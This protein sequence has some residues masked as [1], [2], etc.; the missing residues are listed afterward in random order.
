M[1][2]Q[3]NVLSLSRSYSLI[4][5][6]SLCVSNISCYTGYDNRWRQPQ[7]PPG[8]LTKLSQQA[9]PTLSLSLSLFAGQL[10]C[11]RTLTPRSSCCC[12]CFGFGTACCCCCCL[13]CCYLLL[14]YNSFALFCVIFFAFI[15]GPQFPSL[16]AL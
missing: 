8:L 4:V 15:F 2:T 5:H 6:C 14:L 7:Q 9:S 1:R 12:C 16:F 13:C 3:H 10:C 11:T